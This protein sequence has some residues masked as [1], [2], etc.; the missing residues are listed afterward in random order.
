MRYWLALFFDVLEQQGRYLSRCESEKLADIVES[1]L[2]S[3]KRSL[4]RYFEGWKALCVYYVYN[5]HTGYM[6]K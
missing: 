1:G 5:N 4:M 3:H 6:L 2:Y